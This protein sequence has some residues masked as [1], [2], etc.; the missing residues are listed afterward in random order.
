MHCL[1][2]PS[3][4]MRSVMDPAHQRLV[5]SSTMSSNL[6]MKG[7]YLKHDQPTDERKKLSLIE[8]HCM[9]RNVSYTGS[10]LKVCEPGNKYSPHGTAT[11]KVHDDSEVVAI[12][13][14]TT[15]YPREMLTLGCSSQVVACESGAPCR[16]LTSIFVRLHLLQRLFYLVNLRESVS[17]DLR[18]DHWQHGR[19]D[20]ASLY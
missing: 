9:R 6:H 1:E 15:G 8:N 14:L 16:P 17:K 19:H 18:V 20:K 4:G 7:R 2:S 11:L 13:L 5:A 10:A 3:E 12:S